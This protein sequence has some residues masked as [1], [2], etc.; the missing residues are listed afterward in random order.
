[1]V[2]VFVDRA[3]EHLRAEYQEPLQDI[4]DKDLLS[5]IH[6]GIEKAGNYGITYEKDVLQFLE[7]TISLGADFDCNPELSGIQEILSES[8]DG[9]MKIILVNEYIQSQTMENRAM[10]NRAMEKGWADRK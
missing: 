3:A 7:H 10:E 5:I 1:M 9:T 4:P 6:T 8:I 2:E